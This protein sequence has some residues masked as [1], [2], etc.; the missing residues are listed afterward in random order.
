MI[1]IK[2]TPIAVPCVWYDGIYYM[3]NI[4]TWCHHIIIYIKKHS[5]C[6]SSH[7]HNNNNVILLDYGWFWWRAR[8]C[9]LDACIWMRPSLSHNPREE[10]EREKE[11]VWWIEKEKFF[12]ARDIHLFWS[13]GNERVSRGAR[14]HKKKNISNFLSVRDR[15]LC[16]AK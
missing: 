8:H 13:N 7:D 14:L 15:A 11:C 5:S 16:W 1:I 9:Y 10:R 12:K 2:R 3:L 6:A 4:N